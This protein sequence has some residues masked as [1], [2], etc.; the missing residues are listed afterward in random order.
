MTTHSKNLEKSGNFRAF[1]GSQQLSHSSVLLNF[2]NTE[3]LG[4]LPCP[5][6]VQMLKRLQLNEGF[7]LTL[8]P[9]TLP[10]GPAWGR[11]PQ[12]PIIGSSFRT[13]HVQCSICRGL[14]W[15]NPHWLRMIPTLAT[16]NFGPGV[17]FASPPPRSRSSNIN[18]TSR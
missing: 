7:A 17:G 14:G 2:Q 12:T 11:R 5:F 1:R 10:L 4:N 3:R 16:E 13:R 15:L 8:R 9:G 18:I 6:D